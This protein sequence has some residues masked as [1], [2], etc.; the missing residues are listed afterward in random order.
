M[1]PHCLVE[2]LWKG[3]LKPWEDLFQHGN[4][5]STIEK[6]HDVPIKKGFL[7]GL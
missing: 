6:S 1:V 2:K 3:L 4:G 7:L 5:N